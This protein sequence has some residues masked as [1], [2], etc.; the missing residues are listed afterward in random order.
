MR[1]RLF[2][3]LLLIFSSI[4]ISLLSIEGALRIS[5]IVFNKPSFYQ[6]DPVLGW[7]PIPNLNVR[8]YSQ[9][10]ISG[11]TYPVNYST[12][13]LGC[14]QVSLSSSPKASILVLGDSYT[15]DPYTSN[16][17]AWFSYI[18][19]GLN[20]DICAYG[21]GGSGTYQ[22]LV[23]LSRL[24]SLQPDYLIYQYCSND[25]TDNDPSTILSSYVRN[26]VY[27][28]P[29]LLTDNTNYFAEGLIPSTYRAL[30]NISNLFAF[31]DNQL[32]KAGVV[33]PVT[34][35]SPYLSKSN[36]FPSDPLLHTSTLLKQLSRQINSTYGIRPYAFSCNTDVDS[37]EYATESKLLA[38]AGF[39]F[40]SSPAEQFLIHETNGDSLRMKDGGHWNELGNKVVGLAILNSI[41]NH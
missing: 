19:R 38:D 18:S 8:G 6:S 31:L 15:G 22:H 1:S 12:N 39:I 9:T 10:D 23:A 41:S 26:Q 7:A 30:F 2:I 13:N 36:A 25:I 16:D 40:L 11:N 5:R 21:I 28:R 24:R 3:N 29:F 4:L 17:K 20:A 27:R 32:A 33:V 37:N 34:L 14:R 35:I